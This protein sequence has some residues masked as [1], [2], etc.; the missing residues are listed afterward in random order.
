MQLSILENNAFDGLKKSNL[1]VF[2]IRD[3]CLLFGF[4]KTKAYNVVKSLKKKGAI[5]VVRAGL[6]SL[7]GTSEFVIGAHLNWPSYLSFWSAL[8]YYGF[9]DQ[10]P[11]IVFFA[12][13]RHRKR[14]KGFVFITLSKKRFFGYVP[15]GDIVI[16]QKEKVFVDCL[17]FPRYT[18]GI[19][20]LF[21]SL[22]AGLNQLDE[23][24]LIN[25]A[26]R[27]DSKAV[28]RRL[29]FLLEKAGKKEHLEKLQK[30]IGK[31]FE[32]L[33]P[34]L[35]RAKVFDKKWLLNINW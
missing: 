8:N 30:H 12:S 25:Y 34:S 18:G 33:D 4:D 28:I 20:E 21:V 19:R 7:K 6:F 26:F 11:K 22:K 29:G 15:V 23:R 27:M 1:P 16:A 5:V 32:L 17:L 14:V 24:K 3:I 2:R 35:K 10:L 31:G 13:T 9:S